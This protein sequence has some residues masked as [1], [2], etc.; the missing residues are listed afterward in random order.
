MCT[1]GVSRREGEEG[2]RKKKDLGVEGGEG[3]SEL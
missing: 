3:D 2:R 1:T